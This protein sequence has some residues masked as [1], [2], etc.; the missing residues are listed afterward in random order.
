[1]RK[2]C[3]ARTRLFYDILIN[4]GECSHA[5]G[6]PLTSVMLTDIVFRVLEN[7]ESRPSQPL[8]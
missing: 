4:L 5:L 2:Q 6:S 7:F 1:M 3:I 8:P